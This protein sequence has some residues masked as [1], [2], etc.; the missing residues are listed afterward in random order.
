MHKKIFWEIKNIDNR[1]VLNPK[2]LPISYQYF[3][4]NQI[5]A[6]EIYIKEGFKLNQIQKTL[7]EIF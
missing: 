1:N 4:Q 5:I 3:T 7:K 2:K 6:I